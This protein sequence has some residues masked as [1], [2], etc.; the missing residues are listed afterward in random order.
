MSVKQMGETL[1]LRLLMTYFVMPIEGKAT[2]EMGHF[3]RRFDL[4]SEDAISSLKKS[5]SLN[6]EDIS[7]RVSV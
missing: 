3:V 2:F 6:E 5:I 4:V 7:V 1:L